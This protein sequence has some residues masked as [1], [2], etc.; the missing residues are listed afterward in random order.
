MP[1]AVTGFYGQNVPYPGFS[2]EWGFITS[3]LLIVVLAGGLYLL[4][5]RRGW[6]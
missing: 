4:L 6:L 3:C 2:K 1:T 5:R